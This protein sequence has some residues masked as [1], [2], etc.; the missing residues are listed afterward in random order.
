M[1]KKNNNISINMLEKYCKQKTSDKA[2][3]KFPMSDGEELVCEVKTRLSLEETLRFVEDVVKETV[4]SAD[5]MIVPVAKD[6]ILGKNILTY[7]AN[8]TMPSNA[9]KAY[10]MVMAA[11]DIINAIVQN[12][13]NH[14]F[15]VIQQCIFERVEFEKQKMLS[16][17]EYQINMLIGKINDMTEKMEAAFGGVSGE[18]VAGFISSMSDFAK[19]KN[20]TAQDI[21]AELVKQGIA[22]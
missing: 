2:T 20:V 11:T 5:M 1:A 8:F 21:A 3:L 4:A 7:Y 19:D 14:Q 10:E 6:Y 17:N 15:S 12:V 18:Q 22:R 13:D 16:G 9:S